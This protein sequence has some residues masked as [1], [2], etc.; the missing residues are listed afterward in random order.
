MNATGAGGRRPRGWLR[1]STGLFPLDRN[2]QF[3]SLK[4]LAQL[5]QLDADSGEANVQLAFEVGQVPTV[6]LVDGLHRTT[7]L[8]DL[9]LFRRQNR[10][11]GN[12]HDVVFGGTELL[13]LIGQ[14]LALFDLP[15][16]AQ[17]LHVLQQALEVRVE[18]VNAFLE[19]RGDFA[20]VE[21]DVLLVLDFLDLPVDD[22]DAVVEHA[23][24]FLDETLF[25]DVA[26]KRLIGR[27]AELEGVVM[28]LLASG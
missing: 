23:D 2:L 22:F 7:N 4:S 26:T 25:G 14:L 10:V 8:A 12:H 28:A 27:E 16:L 17:Q 19:L 1:L 9:Q 15:A 20:V 11:H 18:D 21:A 5:F 3:N 6:D 13:D 24:G